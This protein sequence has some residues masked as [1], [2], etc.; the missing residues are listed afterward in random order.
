[1]LLHTLSCVPAGSAVCH[2]FPRA[3]KHYFFRLLSSASK[4]YTQQT[5]PAP[6]PCR[7]PPRRSQLSNTMSSFRPGMSCSTQS[8]SCATWLTCAAEARSVRNCIHGPMLAHHGNNRVAKSGGGCSLPSG[9]GCGLRQGCP[10]STTLF[11]LFIQIW[12]IAWGMPAR[13]GADQ[14]ARSGRWEPRVTD[15]GCA[16][17]PQHPTPERAAAPHRL[18][19]QVPPR[20]RP[21]GQCI[22]GA[23]GMCLPR[24][25]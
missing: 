24:A 19:L 7:C 21:G 1:M 3:S 15:I 5:P 9:V 17:R 22:S 10:L 8:L 16:D 12:T 14:P 2:A 20:A 25:M 18:L 4:Q 23:A 11:N 13:W 6:V